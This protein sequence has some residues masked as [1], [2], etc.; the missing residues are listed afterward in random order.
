MSPLTILATLVFKLLALTLVLLP[1]LVFAFYKAA[2]YW[3]KGPGNNPMGMVKMVQKGGIFL[4]NNVALISH[5]A[6]CSPDRRSFPASPAGCRRKIQGTGRN[7]IKH[8]GK[9]T[10]ANSTGG[11]RRRRGKMPFHSSEDGHITICTL[12]FIIRIITNHCLYFF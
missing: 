12:C 1:C 10:D 7:C 5:F 8:P 9:H 4:P 6:L 11:E 3:L 2:E